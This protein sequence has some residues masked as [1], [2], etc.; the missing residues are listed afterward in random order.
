[1]LSWSFDLAINS[2]PSL[3]FFLW[4]ATLFKDM[5]FCLSNFALMLLYRLLMHFLLNV[6]VGHGDDEPFWS[7]SGRSDTF[8]CLFYFSFGS[9]PTISSSGISSKPAADAVPAA[10][11]LRPPCL[12]RYPIMFLNSLA[13]SAFAS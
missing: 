12:P 11:A 9:G 10:L 2:L 8:F 6:Y 4:I 3:S 1:M 5:A 7:N 13:S